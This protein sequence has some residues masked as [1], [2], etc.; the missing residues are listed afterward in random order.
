MCDK[1]V[2]LKLIDEFHKVIVRPIMLY[3]TKCWL[4][5]K[6]HVQKKKVEKLWILICEDR[7][8]VDALAKL[9]ETLHNSRH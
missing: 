9:Y 1:N 4:I 6:L 2:Q 7:K 8:S 5:K 3:E